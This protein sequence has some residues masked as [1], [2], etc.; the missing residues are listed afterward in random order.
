M[1]IFD[2]DPDNP[3]RYSYMIHYGSHIDLKLMDE[4]A[5]WGC[6]SVLWDLSEMSDLRVLLESAQHVLGILDLPGRDV[7]ILYGGDHTQNC[8]TDA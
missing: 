5:C 3:G 6:T 1:A 8:S 4:E 7:E 2:V